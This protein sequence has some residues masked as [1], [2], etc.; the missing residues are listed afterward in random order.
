MMKKRKGCRRKE[1]DIEEWDK[2]KEEERNWKIRKGISLGKD[3]L[4]KTKMYYM[5]PQV[6]QRKKTKSF[7]NP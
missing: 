6:T 3:T 4:R 1:C 7:I 5:W 2:E